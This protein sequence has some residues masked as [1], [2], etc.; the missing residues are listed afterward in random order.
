MSYREAIL[1]QV[2]HLPP[3]PH[4]AAKVSVMLTDPEIGAGEMVETV[5]Y[6][7][8]LTARIIRMSNSSYMGG[9]G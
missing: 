2:H 6:D 1:E 4:V 9:S 8:G 5:K 3:I 7:P